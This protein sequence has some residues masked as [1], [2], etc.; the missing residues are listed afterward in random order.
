VDDYIFIPGIREILSSDAVEVPAYIIH[1]GVATPFTF[2]L[3]A[4]PAGD[5]Q[6]LLDGC[7]MNYYRN[8]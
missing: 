5:R 2:L 7:P 4:L 6:I 3:E 8:H 1:D